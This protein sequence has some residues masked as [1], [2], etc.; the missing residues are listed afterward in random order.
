MYMC[1]CVYKQMDII[2]NY[3]CAYTFIHI[4]TCGRYMEM[5]QFINLIEYTSNQR[6]QLPFP[7]YKIYK[8]QSQV[9]CN[10]SNKT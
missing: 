7:Q 2:Q 10:K 8:I 9:T 5:Q 1:K 4:C 6:L 3:I